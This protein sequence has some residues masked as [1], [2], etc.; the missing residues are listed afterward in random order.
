[1]LLQNRQEASCLRTVREGTE[2]EQTFRGR[3]ANRCDIKQ[4]LHKDKVTRET[5]CVKWLDYTAWPGLTRKSWVLGKEL[6]YLSEKHFGD[7]FIHSF[8]RIGTLSKE[9]TT[10]DPVISSGISAGLTKSSPGPFTR[11]RALQT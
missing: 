4:H 10:S 11:K 3:R 8:G 7:V 2:H 9:R 6:V 1:M 5:T